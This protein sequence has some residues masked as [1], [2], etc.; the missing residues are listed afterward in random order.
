MIKDNNDN[1]KDNF[2]KFIYNMIQEFYNLYI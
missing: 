1:D 2:D